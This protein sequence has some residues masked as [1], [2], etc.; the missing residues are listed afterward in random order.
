MKFLTR[1]LEKYVDIKSLKSNEL[2]EILNNPIHI[3]TKNLLEE[4]IKNES[5]KK[6]LKRST[7][8]GGDRACI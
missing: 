8:V 2:N 1:E 3:H 4:N 6:Y 5:K 7:G